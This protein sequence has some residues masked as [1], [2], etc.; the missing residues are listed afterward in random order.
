M[1]FL[2][3]S[4]SWLDSG[5]ARWADTFE[6]NW[7]DSEGSIFYGV[8]WCS[9]FYGGRAGG[10]SLLSKALGGELGQASH[11]EI[12]SGF[13]EST[14]APLQKLFRIATELRPSS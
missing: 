3:L 9:G 13:G 2:G 10:D 5:A 6:A 8:L 1:P 7:V 4:G 12:Q 11:R 14:K